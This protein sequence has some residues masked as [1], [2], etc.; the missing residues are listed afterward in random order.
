MNKVGPGQRAYLLAVRLEGARGIGITLHLKTPSDEGFAVAYV[1]DG[2]EAAA[3]TS[4]PL[5]PGAG[6]RLEFPCR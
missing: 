1:L 4:E 2:G 6:D 5:V 3:L